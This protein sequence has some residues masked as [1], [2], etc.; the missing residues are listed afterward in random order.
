MGASNGFPK[1]T[2]YGATEGL[3]RTLILIALVYISLVYG[4]RPLPLP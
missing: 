1:A 2:R 3:Y 4:V